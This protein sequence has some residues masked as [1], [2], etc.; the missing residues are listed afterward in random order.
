MSTHA[1]SRKLPH[2]L[3]AA[4]GVLAASVAVAQIS[5]PRKE[6]VQPIPPGAS[7]ALPQGS[8]DWEETQ[9][10]LLKSAD[11]VILAEVD[12]WK[13]LRASDALGFSD[14]ARFLLTHPGWPDESRL[15]G[16]A[17]RAAS[18]Q[19][20]PSELVAFFRQYPPRTASGG[21]RYAL[22]LLALGKSG[23]AR[24]A[25][26]TAWRMGAT[27]T[28]DE[29]ELLGQFAASFSAEDHDTHA[30]SALSTRNATAAERTLPFLSASV[31][32]IV[33]ARIAMQRSS[34]DAGALMQAAE[35]Y[36]RGHAGYITDKAQWLA[37]NGNAALARDL[38]AGREALVTRPVNAERWYELLLSNA[39]TAAKEG[40]YVLAYGI[41]SRIDDAYPPGTDVSSRPLGERD[42]Y[43]SLAWLAGT[44]ALD[45]LGRPQDA[46]AMFLRYARAARSPQSMSKGY[47]WAGRAAFAAGDGASGLRDMQIAASYP[48]QFYGQLALERL[49][50]AV[51][52]PRAIALASPVSAQD[53]AT[54]EQRSLVRAARALG[55]AA[56]WG[57]QS[58]FL[59]A[60]SASVTT[61]TELV[62]VNDLAGALLRPDLGVM[63]GR[64]ARADGSSAYSLA[65][66][67]RL[68]LPDGHEDHSSIIHA[69][70]RQESQF[71]KNAVSH[72]GAR[73]L[74]QL[75]PGTARETA[76]KIGLV[77]VPDSLTSDIGYNIQL[78][79]S[80]F[81][82]LLTRYDGY[83]PLA[84]AAYN[85][86]P[87]RVR[88]WIAANGDPRQPGGDIMRWIES[89]PISETRNYVQRV[90]E[91]AVVYDA[92]R[93]Q[94]LGLGQPKAPLSRYL[95]KNTDG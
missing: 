75:M 74:M 50:R 22:A 11:L 26:R 14:F 87:G 81:Q 35:P 46:A 17:E 55:L 10:K 58:F 85:A 27:G 64:R 57:D 19:T 18:A 70:A 89:I 30:D 82:R 65:S 12:E 84:I 38:L 33:A 6:I 66:F 8:P 60:L 28:D 3:I 53:R 90:L 5:T 44:L 68:P 91:N 69:I 63:A 9:R 52:A 92:M 47:Y 40:Q 80:Y 67:P 4:G 71:D 34:A 83:Y 49:G 45:R 7:A 32:P 76:G 2:R 61:D 15:R 29:A 88:E 94:R 56:R 93:A 62:L 36:A 1:G 37:A 43:T 24:S 25:A 41:S 77:Y 21:A 51:P 20:S 39:R 13:R 42:D 48:D 86:G 95:G 78:G 73:G 16:L 54:F 59:R 31:R 79:N 23:E 72:A